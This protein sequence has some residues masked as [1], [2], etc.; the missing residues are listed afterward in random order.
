VKALRSPSARG[1]WGD[2]LQRVVEIA[3]MQSFCD[4]DEQVT[5]NTGDGRLRPT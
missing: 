3:G 2:P 1:R 4:F 5:V